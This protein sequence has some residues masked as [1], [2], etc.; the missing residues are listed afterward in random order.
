MR[1]YVIQDVADELAARGDTQLSMRLLAA[2]QEPRCEELL[3]NDHPAV[4]RIREELESILEA[5]DEAAFTLFLRKY[6]AY[7]DNYT[8]LSTFLNS[9]G[10]RFRSET[11]SGDNTGYLDTHPAGVLELYTQTV[12]GRRPVLPGQSLS[13]VEEQ[14]VPTVQSD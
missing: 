11:D 8:Q 9:V 1:E 6:A 2:L 12:Q 5:G 13:L 10:P 7:A 14:P 3:A 4:L